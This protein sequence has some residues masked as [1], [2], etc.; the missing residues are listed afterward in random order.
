MSVH[1]DELWQ[2]MPTGCMSPRE[3]SPANPYLERQAARESNARSYPRRLPLA[4]SK[5]K[6]LYV[7]DTDAGPISTVWPAQGRWRWDTTTRSS[8]K[9]STGCCMTAC[10]FKPWT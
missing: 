10:R 3:L 1:V 4:L 8:S 6:G 7:Q 2:A 9:R 5:G